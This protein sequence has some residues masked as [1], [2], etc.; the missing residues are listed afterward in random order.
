[1]SLLSCF[2]AFGLFAVTASHESGPSGTAQVKC[3]IALE[4]SKAEI[5]AIESD[6]NEGRV[7]VKSVLWKFTK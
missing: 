5:T 4:G 3:L 6:V 7:K 1:M 2:P